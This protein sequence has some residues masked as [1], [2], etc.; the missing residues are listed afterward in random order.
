MFAK[1]DKLLGLNVKGLD[2]PSDISHIYGLAILTPNAFGQWTFSL[3]TDFLSK[4]K[5]VAIVGDLIN[6]ESAIPT[7]ACKDVAHVVTN[8]VNG[9]KG[10]RKGL[11]GIIWLDVVVV[12]VLGCGERHGKA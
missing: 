12:V 6:P 11:A 4:S 5:G 7:C 10:V 2:K 9:R 1:I 8:P 3:D